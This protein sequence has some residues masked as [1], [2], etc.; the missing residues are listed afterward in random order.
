MSKSNAMD[1]ER[2][3]LSLEGKQKAPTMAVGEENVRTSFRKTLRKATAGFRGRD[4][5]EAYADYE[6]VVAAFLSGEL[7]GLLAKAIAIDG[8]HQCPVPAAQEELARVQAD[9]R[10]ADQD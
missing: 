8:G 7:P 3:K 2:L 6:K 9:G 5:K 4:D 1:A 10:S